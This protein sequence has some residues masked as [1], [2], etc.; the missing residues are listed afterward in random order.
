MGRFKLFLPLIIFA[1]LTV[2]FLSVLQDESYDPQALPSALIDKPFPQFQLPALSNEQLQ[3]SN[4]DLTGEVSLVNVW[5]TWC[6]SCRVE[7]PHLNRIAEE[8]KVPIIGINYKDEN[9]L[10]KRWLNKLGNPYKLN[11]VDA[12]GRLGLDLGVYGAP[13]T[14]VIDSRGIIRLKHVGVVDD[15]VWTEKLKPVVEKLRGRKLMSRLAFIVFLLAFFPSAYAV[16]ET[17]QF[18]S[19]EQKKSLSRFC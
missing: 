14:Y 15:K 3:L 19:D 11:I 9:E 17:Y 4:V 16:I 1:A 18:D 8:E 7:H 10:A 2:L 13:E 12:D 6:G 5:A